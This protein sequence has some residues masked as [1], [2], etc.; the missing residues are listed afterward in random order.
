MLSR[1]SSVY[2]FVLVAILVTL[3]GAKAQDCG[4]VVCR[5]VVS[6]VE[7]LHTATGGFS[8]EAYKYITVT[9]YHEPSGASAICAGGGDFDRVDAD[10]CTDL[11]NG[12]T[13]VTDAVGNCFYRKNFGLNGIVDARQCGVYGDDIHDDGD[14]LNKCMQ[15]A[16]EQTGSG[17]LPN[18]YHIVTTGGGVVLSNST[19]ILVPANTEL[20]CGGNSTAAVQNNDYRH[21][22]NAIVL[23]PTSVNGGPFTVKLATSTSTYV[24]CSDI[25]GPGP[26]N[27]VTGTYPNPYSPM[28]WYPDCPPGSAPA[29]S[30]D[31]PGTAYLRSAINEYSA[32]NPNPTALYNDAASCGTTPPYHCGPASAS[33][34]IHLTRSEHLTVRN[35]TV[36]GFGTCYKSDDS[37]DPSGGNKPG[38]RLVTD[39]LLCDGDT[40]INVHN[41]PEATQFNAFSVRP[42][43]TSGDGTLV[44]MKVDALI[45]DPASTRYKAYVEVPAGSDPNL[46]RFQNGDTV[47][48]P[49]NPYD[50]AALDHSG[51]GAESAAGRWTAENVSA[52]FDHSTDANCNTGATCQSFTLNGS[53]GDLD[54]Q[55]TSISLSGVVNFTTVNGLPPNAI[56]IVFPPNTDPSKTSLQLVAVGQTVTG[57]CIPSGA[58]VT[59]VWPAKALVY[60]SAPATCQPSI[61]PVTVTFADNGFNPLGSEPI[62]SN[63][64]IPGCAS[65]DA[66]ERFGDGIVIT[67]SGGVAAVNCQVYEHLTAYHF[68]TNA[69]SSRFSNCATGENTALP[70]QEIVALKIDGEHSTDPNEPDA[71]GT[72]FVNGILGQ[73]RTVGILVQ[74]NCN[75]PNHL[76][77]VRFAGNGGGRRNGVALELDAGA[78][79]ITNGDAFGSENLLKADKTNLYASNGDGTYTDRGQFPAALSIGNNQLPKTK[80]IMSN[81]DAAASTNGCGN[82]FAAPTPY[83][84]AQ[85]S[86]THAPGGRLTLTAC[87]STGR[88]VPVMTHDAVNAGNIYYVPYLNQEVPIF[89]PAAGL[90]GQADI[91]M[92]GLT[93]HLNGV[94]HTATHIYDVFVETLDPDAPGAPELCTGPA[95]SSASARTSDVVQVN[96]VWVNAADM[97]CDYNNDSAAHR[98]C[99]PQSCTYLGSFYATANAET[100]QQFGPVSGS[101]GGAPCLCLY[102]AYN[103]VTVTSASADSSAAYSYTGSA[104]RLMNG[105]ANNSVIVIDGL[106][107]MQIS[108]QLNDVLQTGTGG[109]A[110]LMRID[111]SPS[112]VSPPTPSLIVQSASTARGSYSTSVTTPPF[113]G[114][115]TAQAVETAGVGTGGANFGGGGFQRLSVQVSD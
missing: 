48:I 73:H 52:T 37:D 32:F 26:F 65:V 69:N 13:I 28:L 53:L 1:K 56:Q 3:A 100:E 50:P 114:L 15:F 41:S 62:C 91:G 11:H 72:E 23:N 99:L 33:V 104:W 45:K 54:S 96:G 67:D 115:W 88:C 6:S 19:D 111:F 85:S 34:G 30:G 64:P 38:K 89:S 97:S 8:G 66:N 70:D 90:F 35:V 16:A 63:T 108:A 9:C 43:L 14:A 22:T 42:F 78:V 77:N 107:Q 36:L 103:H 61:N 105:S 109:R 18:P 79:T 98:D 44:S 40:G 102:N 75:T 112:L 4:T 24:D 82:T 46:F 71:C 39:H 20:T 21:I 80:L 87:D 51:S 68:S 83:L 55:A 81:S 17:A 10:L 93:L 86:F 106:Q 84:C 58:T 59:D 12:A 76:T 57:T 74:S 95:W 31:T 25:A 113:P 7:V 29:C 101:G 60:I 110:A 27:G 49:T 5:T 2:G 92:T 47:W 94:K